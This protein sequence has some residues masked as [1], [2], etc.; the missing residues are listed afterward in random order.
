MTWINEPKLVQI[1]CQA[2]HMRRCGNPAITKFVAGV[3]A[4][5]NRRRPSSRMSLSPETKKGPGGGSCRGRVE[6]ASGEPGTLK[7]KPAYP[8]HRPSL[9]NCPCI[10]FG[11]A[12]PPSSR[13]RL[14]H[15]KCRYRPKQTVR[16]RVIGF[17]AHANNHRQCVAHQC[18]T[19][20]LS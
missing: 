10:C 1:K 18:G 20:L 16:C 2:I 5:S 7:L 17:C 6:W 9:V 13:R 4:L 11:E 14:G 15:P 19:P 8:H 3:I 12:K